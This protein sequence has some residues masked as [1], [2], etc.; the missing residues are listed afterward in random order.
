MNFDTKTK[1]DNEIMWNETL[2]TIITGEFLYHKAKRNV[3]C[4]FVED[5]EL[6][7]AKTSSPKWNYY[8]YF[9]T[10][11]LPGFNNVLFNKNF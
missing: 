10:F 1:K 6:G 5:T 2:Q 4:P 3:L 7:A 11:N 8:Y 9:S